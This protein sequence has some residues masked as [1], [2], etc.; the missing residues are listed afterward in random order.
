MDAQGG[1]DDRPYLADLIHSKPLSAQSRGAGADRD[2]VRRHIIRDRGNSSA[3]RMRCEDRCE[4]QDSSQ[5]EVPLVT[6]FSVRA[7]TWRN[8]LVIGS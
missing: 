3:V 8:I 5:T 6:D 7:M 4:Q 2:Q 1:N